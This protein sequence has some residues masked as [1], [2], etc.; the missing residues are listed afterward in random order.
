MDGQLLQLSSCLSRTCFSSLLTEIRNPTEGHFEKGSGYKALRRDF[1][2][3]TVA[4]WGAT[5]GTHQTLL[6][7][8]EQTLR[9]R[10]RAESNIVQA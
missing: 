7:E 2:D 10:F 1:A 9:V 6:I 8:V 4:S 3:R 5:G